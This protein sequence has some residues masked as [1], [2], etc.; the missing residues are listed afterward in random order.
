MEILRIAENI[1][2]EGIGITIEIPGSHLESEHTL[3]VT[4]LSDSSISSLPV[5]AAGGTEI[6]FYLNNKYDNSYLVDLILDNSVIF[7]QEY[8]LVRP[9]VNPNT[10]GTTASEIAEYTK[11]ENIARTIID[12]YAD[13]I[14]FYNKKSILQT[15]GSNSDYMPLWKNANTV[16]KVYEDN[17]LIYS[18]EDVKI[19]IT[20]FDVNES[21]TII[22]TALDNGYVFGDIVTLYGFTD[23]EYDGNYRLLEILSPTQFRIDTLPSATLNGLESVKRF[24]ESEFRVTPDKSA[25]Y[26]V[27]RGA[28]ARISSQ[29]IKMPASRGDIATSVFNYGT[30]PEKYDYLFVLDEGFKTIPADI[31][32]ATEMLVDD[33]KCGRLDYYQRYITSYNTDQ[34]KIQFDKSMLQGTGNIIVDKILDKYAKS[35]TKVGVL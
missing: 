26:R 29:T 19:S 16:L 2:S 27:E 12:N 8:Y 9:Y 30:F 6:T 31:V 11:W 3:R 25:I 17:V 1:S 28:A 21:G 18:L 32:S 24:W 5:T 20:D 15:Q 14:S 34:F 4:D 7:S 10:L 33:L 35:I 22:T 13:G 23:T